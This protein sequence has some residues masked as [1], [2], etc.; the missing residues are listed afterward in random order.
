M[1][2]NKFIERI[3]LLQEHSY[4]K[5]QSVYEQDKGMFKWLVNYPATIKWRVIMYIYIYAWT[6]QGVP[7]WW[8]GVPLSN[9]LGFKHNPLEGAG[10]HVL[11]PNQKMHQTKPPKIHP[12]TLA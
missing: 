2:A 4:E 1:S 3:T 7:N 9:P 11:L 8:Y 5:E 6:L 10:I 12:E